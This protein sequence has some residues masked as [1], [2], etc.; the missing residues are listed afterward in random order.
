MNAYPRRRFVLSMSQNATVPPARR[1]KSFSSWGI[2]V[3]SYGDGRRPPPTTNLPTYTRVQII[4]DNWIPDTCTIYTSVVIRARSG[5]N[6]AS[7]AID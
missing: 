5:T 1:P 6:E 4:D 3:Q 2:E 7:Y